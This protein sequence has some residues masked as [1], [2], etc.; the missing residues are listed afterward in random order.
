MI[1]PNRRAAT[2]RISTCRWIALTLVLILAPYTVGEIKKPRVGKDTPEGQFLE[3]VSLETDGGK[4]IAL[5]EQFLTIFPHCDM[6][7]TAWVYGELQDRHRRAGNVDKALAAGER[8][9][10]LEPDNVEVARANWVLA[11]KK[12]DAELIKK[13]SGETAKIAERVVNLPLP[14]D[15]DEGK[16]ANDRIEFARQFVINTA[17]EEYTKAVGIQAPAERIAALEDFT[18]KKP[19][20]PYLDQIEVAEFLS[21]KEMGDLEKTLAAAEKI[22]SHNENREDALLFVA[23]VNFRRKKDPKRSLALAKKFIERMAVAEKPEGISDRDWT[24]AKT[25]NLGLAHYIIGR[26]SFDSEQWP[27]AD[28]ALRAAL[29][30][31]GDNQFRATVLNDLGWANYRMLNAVDAIKFYGLCAAIPGAL[32]EQ[33]AKSV[34]SIKSEYRL[35]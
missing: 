17:Y 31:I 12:G 8:I 6:A 35:P 3:L 32:Q 5:L 26:I 33:A 10:E 22:L 28:R 24:N 34:L 1:G 2:F 30:L 20:N 27:V 29:P 21:Y 25:Q 19:Q 14:S 4:K 18:R 16:M 11:E 15:P 13:W 9:L 23:E 7:L